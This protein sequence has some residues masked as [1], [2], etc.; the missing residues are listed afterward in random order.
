MRKKSLYLIVTVAFTLILGKAT[1]GQGK[2]TDKSGAASSAS[3]ACSSSAAQAGTS[4]ST[5][6]TAMANRQVKRMVY[7]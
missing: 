4:Q 3:S 5:V 6:N 1:W 7:P 2:P